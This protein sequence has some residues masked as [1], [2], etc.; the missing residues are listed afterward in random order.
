MKID[1]DLIFSYSL[2]IAIVNLILTIIIM[3]VTYWAM[4]LPLTLELFTGSYAMGYVILWVLNI[5]L[6]EE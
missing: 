6:I 1:V 5:H 2:A 3:S 4:K